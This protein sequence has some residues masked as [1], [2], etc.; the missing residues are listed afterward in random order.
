[1]EKQ[2]HEEPS[3]RVFNAKR[4]ERWSPAATTEDEYD[5]PARKKLGLLKKRTTPHENENSPAGDIRTLSGEG[6]VTYRLGKND[7]QIQPSSG[8]WINL[9]APP[10]PEKPFKRS[11]RLRPL[12]RTK[13]KKGVGFGSL[14]EKGVVDGPTGGKEKRRLAFG[15]KKE[16]KGTHRTA[17]REREDQKKKKRVRTKP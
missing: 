4:K 2:N 10:S 1:L 9:K 7:G 15:G 3:R 5:V 11:K 14:R 17:D 8:K 16:V 12:C 6:E 13:G